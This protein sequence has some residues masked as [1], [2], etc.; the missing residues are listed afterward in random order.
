M[1]W[2]RSSLLS[3]RVLPW[4]LIFAKD[5]TQQS[6]N[7]LKCALVIL[8]ISKQVIYCLPIRRLEKWSP[9]LTRTLWILAKAWNMNAVAVAGVLRGRRGAGK[10]AA[11]MI[12]TSIL[13]IVVIVAAVC[14]VCVVA[15]E[16]GEPNGRYSLLPHPSPLEPL[17]PPPPAPSSLARPP[18]NPMSRCLW[19]FCP[20]KSAIAFMACLA[21]FTVWGSDSLTHLSRVSSYSREVISSSIS[22]AQL[23]QTS[24]TCSSMHACSGSTHSLH[25][26][27]SGWISITG[28]DFLFDVMHFAERLTVING[29]QHDLQWRDHSCLGLMDLG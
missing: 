3:P 9:S 6:H 13:V 11:V 2:E 17:P 1:I 27:E 20:S 15:T 29:V 7:L 23:A 24:I 14:A 28:C 8:D 10:L 25:R 19:E 5:K 12:S 22:L 21:Y 26:L 18:W 16:S 4:R